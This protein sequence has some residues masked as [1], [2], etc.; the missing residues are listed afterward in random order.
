MR[1]LQPACRYA[2]GADWE[3][4]TR[5]AADRI[6]RLAPGNREAPRPRPGYLRSG[7]HGARADIAQYLQ[8]NRMRRMRRH[9]ANSWWNSAARAGRK[10]R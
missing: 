2:E 10:E 1:I 7:T 5:S 8:R 4:A 9:C 3:R 6:L